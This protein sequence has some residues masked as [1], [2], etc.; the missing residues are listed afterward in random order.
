MVGQPGL[1]L[2]SVL[3][4]TFQGCVSVH[5]CGDCLA[6]TCDAMLSSSVRQMFHLSAVS[7]LTVR[8]A[9]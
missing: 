1:L 7:T 5:M 6:Q 8:R 9:R 2:C 4:R 3:Q